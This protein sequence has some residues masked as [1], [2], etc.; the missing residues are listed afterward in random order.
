MHH[1][2]ASGTS[3]QA[4]SGPAQFQIR[5]PRAILACSM[6][7]GAT[8]FDRFDSLPGSIGTRCTCRRAPP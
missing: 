5:T 3:V 6:H 1:F 4:V 2:R 7:V 8:R